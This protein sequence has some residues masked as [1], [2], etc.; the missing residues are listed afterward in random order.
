VV[1]TVLLVVALVVAVRRPEARLPRFDS[2]ATVGRG[3]PVPFFDAAAKRAA[4]AFVEANSAPGEPLYVGCFNHRKVVINDLDLYFLTDR[5][6]VSRYLQ[7]DP[8][9]ITRAEVQLEVVADFKRLHPSVAIVGLRCW[10]PEPNRSREPGATLLDG[11][12]RSHYQI[13]Q[14]V[15][16]YLF[17][18]RIPGESDERRRR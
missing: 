13:V 14:K 17:L 18:K 12:I 8:G 4:V 6:G 10:W 16:P 15:E 3:A 9:V 7:F 11:Y 5:V 2:E 1:L